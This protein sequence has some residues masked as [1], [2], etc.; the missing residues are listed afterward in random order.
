MLFLASIS[1][2]RPGLN[3]GHRAV[4]GG[5]I[6]LA[7]GVD[8]RGAVAVGVGPLGRRTP[9]PSWRPGRS[10]CRLRGTGTPGRRR[11]SGE[12]TS[13]VLSRARP[14]V[15]VSVVGDVALAGR[16]E[17]E[18]R[19]VLGRRHHD[20]PGHGHA[21]RPRTAAW[22]C[23]CPCGFK[24]PQ[25]QISLP[26]FRSWADDVVGAVREQVLAL[27]VAIEH[28]R[29][30][31]VLALGAGVA[32]AARASRFPCRWPCRARSTVPPPLWMSCRVQPVAV[33]HRRRGHAELR[34]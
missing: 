17:A 5:E 32:G 3:H 7:V 11:T 10:A 1:N 21:A 18:H 6:D 30:V 25:R 33:E 2:L 26:S 8:G 14:E 22:G 34:C 19:A 13:G 31:R 23:S 27:A 29:S 12:G 4:A 16:I 28:R 20:Q 15:P 24:P 9:R